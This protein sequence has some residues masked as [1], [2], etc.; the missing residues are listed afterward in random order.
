MKTVILDYGAGNLGSVF[1]FFKLFDS[2]EVEIRD[3]LI[4]IERIDILIIPGVGSFGYG[5]KRLKNMK[6]LSSKIKKF[7]NNGGLLVGIC[8][9]AQLFLENSEESLG[10][11][12]LC[13]VNGG[14]YFLGSNKKYIES[15]PRV[16]WDEISWPDSNNVLHKRY[17]YFV[18]SY[19]MK[20]LNAQK[21]IFTND[22]IVAAYKNK[23][24]WGLQFH[25]EKS[26]LCGYNILK[27]ILS[28]YAEEN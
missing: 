8:L 5:C 21:I 11:E 28:T 19:E 27:S 17:C 14:S 24:I 22:G 16:G 6:G 3:N 12:G 7:L 13:L 25:P 23:N 15:I 1:K 20:P 10:S 18:H 26:N 9:G 2:L 4:D